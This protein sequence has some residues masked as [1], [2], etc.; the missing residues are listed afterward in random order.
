MQ[1]NVVQWCRMQY[2]TIQ[3]N[4][5][6]C[7]T[8]QCRTVQY[9]TMLCRTMQCSAVQCSEYHKMF[10]AFLYVFTEYSGLER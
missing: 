8:V 3:Y 2:I 6:L 7:S 5:V 9:N 4:V 10:M 1:Y